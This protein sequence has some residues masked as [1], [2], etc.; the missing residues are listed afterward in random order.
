MIK[1]I[2]MDKLLEKFLH[3]LSGFFVTVS[4]AV[5]VA[6]GV[7]PSPTPSVQETVITE[8]VTSPTPEIS[9]SPSPITTPTSK[10]S[11][12]PT[13]K[14]SPSPSPTTDID[15]VFESI[16]F[17][18]EKISQKRSFFVKQAY[19]IDPIEDQIISGSY[20]GPFHQSN[21][22]KSLLVRIRN[23]GH[24]DAKEVEVKII[25]D[26]ETL[27]VFKL[28][29]INKQSLRGEQKSDIKFP[30]KTGKHKIE[31]QVNPDKKIS[32]TRYDNNSK[33]VEYEYLD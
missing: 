33:I 4:T 9:P 5:M 14:P 19:A 28:D 1:I 25:A 30:D 26:G 22:I 7:Q 18:P 17:S 10:P 8:V 13:I 29:K 11:P 23:N 24:E 27:S 15:L 2:D 32:E 16:G 21:K 20:I 31:A 6:F 3:S 12:S